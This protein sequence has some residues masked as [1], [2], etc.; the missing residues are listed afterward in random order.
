[1]KQNLILLVTLTLIVLTTAIFGFIFITSNEMLSTILFLIAVLLMFFALKVNSNFEYYRHEFNYLNLISHK[2]QRVIK[3]TELLNSKHHQFLLKGLGYKTKAAG[4]NITLYYKISDGIN[5]KRRNK[6]LYSI[7]I[8]KDDIN[9]TDKKL[10]DIFENLEGSLSKG[11]SFYN[12][13]FFQFKLT[14]NDISNDDIA[15]T[16]KIFFIKHKRH[17][18][19]VLN[20]IYNPNTK[21]LYYLRGKNFKPVFFL[22]FAIQKLD[23][24][25]SNN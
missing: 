20:V 15:E 4:D 22:D 5:S 17:S 25:L 11:E 9:F 21:Y 16:D 8:Y 19:V 10:S 23:T 7:L 1:M 2:D 18:V 6:T 14:N 3:N 24:I 13:V 12:R